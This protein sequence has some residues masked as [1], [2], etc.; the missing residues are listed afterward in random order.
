MLWDRV[1]GRQNRLWGEAVRTWSPSGRRVGE[2]TA[3]IRPP[4]SLPAALFPPRGSPVPL[5]GPRAS[6]LDACENHC[7]GLVLPEGGR[8]ATEASKISPSYLYTL[9]LEVLVSWKKDH[10]DVCLIFCY[11]VYYLAYLLEYRYRAFSFVHCCFPSVWRLCW[12]RI[13]NLKNFFELF[14][15]LPPIM[16]QAFY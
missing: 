15:C 11:H 3:Q 7:I 1:T 14:S 12:I 9:G 10:F 2:K 13:E 16:S 5:P 4:P 6:A 8:P